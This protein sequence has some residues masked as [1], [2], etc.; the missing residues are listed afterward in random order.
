MTQPK[1]MSLT[2]LLSEVH[3][4][5]PLNLLRH[6]VLVQQKVAALEEDRDGWRQLSY[7][8]A[9]TLGT[10]RGQL[11]ILSQIKVSEET[12]LVGRTLPQ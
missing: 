1:D 4:S 3:N 2:E 11:I 8:Y 5:V 9:A 12:G 6:I 10:M 7:S